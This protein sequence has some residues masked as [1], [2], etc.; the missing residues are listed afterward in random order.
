MGKLGTRRRGPDKVDLL[1]EGKRENEIE[2]ILRKERFGDIELRNMYKESTNLDKRGYTRESLSLL[3]QIHSQRP[4]DTRVICRMSRTMRTLGDIAGAERVLREGIK[5]L[6]KAGLGERDDCSYVKHALATTLASRGEV[7]EARE[8]WSNATGSPN[9]YH[10][11]GR[12]EWREGNLSKAVEILMEGERKW[13]RNSRI[14]HALGGIYRELGEHDKAREYY[15]EALKITGRTGEP[16]LFTALGISYYETGDITKARDMFRRGTSVG[17]GGHSEGWMA[18]GRMEEIEGERMKAKEVYEEG[19]EVGRNYRNK[20]WRMFKSS[21][22]S[23]LITSGSPSSAR[24][25]IRF[26]VSSDPH[27]WKMWLKWGKLEADDGNVDKAREIFKAATGGGNK[28]EGIAEVWRAWGETEMDVLNYVEARR[29]LMEGVKRVRNRNPRPT[30]S[31]AEL[32]HRWGISEYYC[33]RKGRARSCWE[34]ALKMLGCNKAGGQVKEI[35]GGKETAARVYQSM[36]KAELEEGK[37]ELAGYYI[38]RSIRIGGGGEGR[39]GIWADVVGKQGKDELEIE[40]RGMED[41]VINKG[42]EEGGEGGNEVRGKYVLK[43]GWEREP[44]F[45]NVDERFE[46]HVEEG[47]EKDED[48]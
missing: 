9:S 22:V 33:G 24:S 28:G 14:K 16:F 1:S 26:C 8:L 41:C 17:G 46:I 37:L 38:C 48:E 23:F 35:K 4:L 40:L 47:E 7:T 27:D 42:G 32:V 31:L 21:Y 45:R 15:K 34:A 30:P 20:S 6:G 43:R 5:E 19:W 10:A 29:V 36:A 12:M 11:W 44:F 3:I 2:R 18:W 39:F 25:I 13:K